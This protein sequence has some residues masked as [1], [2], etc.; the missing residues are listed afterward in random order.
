MKIRNYLLVVSF[1][2][3]AACVSLGQTNSIAGT[4]WVADDDGDVTT[5]YFENDGTL[6]YTY[7]GKSYRNGTWKQ[8]GRTVSFEMNE[9]YRTFS[10]TIEGDRITGSSQNVADK[11]WELT[12]Y[13]YR[14]PNC[15]PTDFSISNPCKPAGS[16]IKAKPVRPRKRT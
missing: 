16:T 14:H 4:L 12:M 9:S 1:I 15:D 10:G 5:F 11:S 8:S 7:N 2:F 6:S 13:R 3:A